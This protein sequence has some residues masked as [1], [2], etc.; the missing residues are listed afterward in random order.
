MKDGLAIGVKPLTD[1]QESERYFDTD[2]LSRGV[3]AIYISAEN[4][5]SPHNFRLLKERFTLQ[6]ALK[7]EA[8]VS[9]SEQVHSTGLKAV[10]YILG[11][12]IVSTYG[13]LAPPLWPIMR[14][15]DAHEERVKRKFV[16]EELEHRTMTMAMGLGDAV[17]GFVYFRRPPGFPG[18]GQV[19][20]H[21][22]AKDTNTQEVTA[23]D[24]ILNGK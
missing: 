4:R 21:L 3:L 13:L 7:E 19:V 23:F 20:L 18:S 11:L 9:D 10:E 5:E 14:G 2:L 24:F 8:R 1:T 22:E 6:T 16:N 15:I 12:A 17:H